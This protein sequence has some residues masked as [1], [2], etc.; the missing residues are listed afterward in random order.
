MTE[1]LGGDLLYLFTDSLLA[2]TARVL[3]G[4][5]SIVVATGNPVIVWL[6]VNS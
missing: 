1:D 3:G 6:V 5:Y 4:W 2:T